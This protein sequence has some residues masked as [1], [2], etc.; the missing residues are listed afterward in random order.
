MSYLGTRP[1]G[2]AGRLVLAVCLSM[3]VIMVVGGAVSLLGPHLG[4]PHPLNPGPERVIWILLFVAVLTIG[5]VKKRD[6]VRWIF[7][8]VRTAEIY[9]TFACA[10]LP[11]ISILG[12]AQL[13]RTGNDRLALFSSAL[14]VV[15]LLAAVVGGWSRNSRWPLNALLYSASLALLLSTSLRGG[16]LYGWDVQEEF[17]IA[18]S[19]VHAGVWVAPAN[20]NPYGAMLSLTVLPAIL[21]SLVRLRLLAFFQLVVPAIMALLPLAVFSTIRSVPRWITTG[22]SAPRPGLAFAVVVALI[23]SSVAFSSEL[24]SITRQA[25]ALT[26][27]TALIMVMFSRAMLKRPA[28]IV[29]GLLIVEIAFTHYTTSYLLAVIFLCSWIVGLMWSRGWIGT[30]RLKIQ[31]HRYDVRSRKI[32]NFGLVVVALV[33]AFGWNLVI[34]PNDALNQPA[35]AVVSKGTGF[36]SST[37]TVILTPTQFERIFISEFQ[38]SAPWMKR[39]PGSKSVHLTAAKVPKTRGVVPRLDGAWKELSYLTIESVWLML[40]ISL[41]YGIFFLGRRRSYEYSSDLVGLGVSGLLIGGI[42]R[43]SGT[44]A[45]FYDPERA[46]IFTAIL[47]AAPVTLFLDDVVSYL[48]HPKSLSRSVVVRSLSGA[49]LFLVAVLIFGAAGL[50]A[51]F[52][53]GQAPGSLSARDANADDFTVSTPEFATAKWLQGNVGSKGLVQSDFFG[54]L[55]LLSEPG[56]YHLVVELV[57]PEVDKGA[58]IYLSTENLRERLSQAETPD[59]VFQTAYKSTFHFFNRNFYVV[60]STGATR[61]Y[62]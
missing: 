31:K 6:P 23:I 60:Y 54:Q 40:G 27:V 46:A 13:N 5:V 61:V 3:M 51:W 24:V 50:G 19:T 26:L 30:P 53:G 20:R 8:S 1:E 43:F 29:V 62:H 16:H 44:L 21:H 59:G 2:T 41:L 48:S 15:T 4:V 14:D 37:N 45:S 52:F 38:K 7:E 18:L 22:R 49:S 36:E 55:V 11:L 28:Q 39:V 32:I 58:Y 9:C 42:L 47:L 56:A 17:G 12:V 34:A 35:S 25:M 33:A 10:V 57:P